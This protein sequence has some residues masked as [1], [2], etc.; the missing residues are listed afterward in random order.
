MFNCSVQRRRPFISYLLIN[1]I[2]IY[3]HENDYRYVVNNPY[4]LL[5]LKKNNNNV[6][7]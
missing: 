1:Y 4:Y 2:T 3:F 6:G 5:N 7:T